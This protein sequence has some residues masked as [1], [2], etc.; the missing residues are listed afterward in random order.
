MNRNLGLSA[1]FLALL[2]VAF[3]IASPPGGEKSSVDTKR[4]AAKKEGGGAK[5]APEKKIPIEGPWLASQYFYGSADTSV[6]AGADLENPQA[7]LDCAAKPACQDSLK[8]FFGIKPG[9]KYELLL[10]TVPDPLHTRLSL[11]T[12]SSVQSIQNAADDA[13]WDFA[14][15]WLPWNDHVNPDEKDAEER[16]TQRAIIRAQEKQP[17]LLIFRGAEGKM[18]RTL[19]VFLVGETPTAGINKVQFQL[20]RAYSRLIEGG[21]DVRVLGPTFSGSF[22]SLAELILQEPNKQFVVRTGTATNQRA[23]QAVKKAAKSFHSANMNS[24]EHSQHFCDVLSELRIDTSQAALLVEDETSFARGVEM[25]PGCGEKSEKKVALIRFPRDISHLRN[26]YRETVAASQSTQA[27][28]PEVDFS[29]KDPESG[30]DSVPIYSNAQSPVSQNAVLSGIMDMIRE[31]RLRLVELQA[32]NV[33]DALFL[34][35]ILRQQCPDTRI[36]IPFPDLLFTQA[37]SSERWTGILGL[38]TYPLFPAAHEWMGEGLRP[39][40]HS[41]VNA[42]GV[43]NAA[44]LLFGKEEHLSDYRWRNSSYPPTWLLSLDRSGF[45]PVRVFQDGDRLDWFQRVTRSANGD[46]RLPKPPGLWSLATTLLGALGLLLGFWMIHLTRNNHVCRLAWLS[47]SPVS[48]NLRCATEDQS[49]QLFLL[50]SILLV[51]GLECVLV[52][53]L[54]PGRGDFN[55]VSASLSVAAAVLLPALAVYILVGYLRVANHVKAALACLVL[56]GAGLMAWYWL[57]HGFGYDPTDRADFFSMRVTSMRMGSSP[58]IPLMA[59]VLALLGFTVTQLYRF[60]LAFNQQPKV[61]AWGMTMALDS[62]LQ[63]S[64]MELK[65]MFRSVPSLRADRVIWGFVLLTMATILFR[66][67]IYMRSVDGAVYD[68][69]CGT[70]QWLVLASLLFTAYQIVVATGTL[71]DMLV[72]LNC[73]PLARAFARLEVQA[74]SQPI[75]FRRFHLQ[76]LDVPIRAAVILHD[77]ERVGRE[78]IASLVGRRAC[79]WRNGYTE[80]VRNL[81]RSDNG[82]TRLQRRDHY[83]E[84]RKVGKRVAGELMTEVLIPG[85]TGRILLDGEEDEEAKAFAGNPNDSFDLAQNFVALQYTSFLIYALRQI[86]NL[87]WFLSVG[88]LLTVVSMNA[89]SFQAPKMIGRFLLFVFV[90][91]GVFLWRCLA[92]LERDPILSRI[93]GSKPGELNAE[94]YL[95]LLG[96]GALPLLGVLT[97]QFPSISNFALSWLQPTLEALH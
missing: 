42:E 86:Q 81:V 78:H 61:P 57:C 22:G 63:E 85:W 30:E 28:A 23:A 33:L 25:A 56:F 53:P 20:A 27:Q 69:L 73:L 5:K 76:A 87:L 96:Y 65:R 8:S 52:F 26:V 45:L 66:P 77:L 97:S 36:L 80:A 10:A 15:Q 71:K 47:M 2:A 13:E 35:R 41:S 67:Y 40:F 91:L 44:L 6:Q 1:G 11:Y 95:R 9:Q 59:A 14:T 89:Y 38:A 7:I 39:R 62:R 83:H 68:C 75:W 34:V 3:H 51:A 16:R 50:A 46:F 48:D 49:R 21:E 4:T 74:G 93:A 84:L 94:F 29:L 72:S 37:D 82:F 79:D 88:F 31:R 32:T 70:L 92:K 19:F 60:H 55:L 54:R 17:G 18:G 24:T 64:Y 90:A 43:Y 58:A 12:D